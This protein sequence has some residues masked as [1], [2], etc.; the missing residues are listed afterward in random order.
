M[1]GGLLGLSAGASLGSGCAAIAGE[2]TIEAFFIVGKGTDADFDGWSEYNFDEPVDPDQ[3]AT[4][5]R[6]MLNA[7]A[8]AGDLTFIIDVFAEAVQPDGTRTPLA[9]GSNFPKN[10]TIAPLEILYDGNLRPLLYPD[11][12]KLRIEWSGHFDTTYPHPDKGT[13]VEAQVV[14]EIL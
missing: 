12:M 1:L 5:E 13:R 10:D 2:E 7:P 6:V 3:A 14:V 11:G 4:L 9:S 8:G